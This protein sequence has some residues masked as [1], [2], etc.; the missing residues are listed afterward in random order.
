MQ[1]RTLKLAGF[2]S[3]VEPVE[4]EIAAGLTGIVGPNGC[5]KSNIVEALRWAMGETSA[6][7]MRGGEMD[8]VIFSGSEKRPA[9]NIAEVT[10]VV[11]NDGG[12][13]P[14][15]FEKSPDLEVRRRIERGAGSDY[16]VNGRAVRARDVQL[17]FA[18]A[19]IGASSP[20]MV[21]QG[22]ISAL[23]AAKPSERRFILEDAAG[24]GGLQSR[25]HEAEL[26]L[27]AAE[28]NL[29]QLDT[30]LD[31][32]Q[33]RQSALKRQARQ[34]EKYRQ[35]AERIREI[36][37]LLLH[38]A[39]SEAGARL[40]LAGLAFDE[41]ETSVRAA[42][43]QVASAAALESTMDVRVTLARQEEARAQETLRAARSNQKDVQAQQ[44]Q[45]ETARAEA[46]RDIARSE[47]DLAHEERERD[48][49]ATA[50]ARLASERATLET[51]QPRIAESLHFAQAAEQR[52]LE[53]V[54]EA[55]SAVLS[56]S[57]AIARGETEQ[58][59]LAKQIG[60]AEQ[61]QG[62][63]SRRMEAAQRERDAAVRALSAG[64]DCAGLEAEAEEARLALHAAEGT[65]D[66]V[67]GERTT[68]EA[69]YTDMRDQADAARGAET[70]L[71]AEINGL[72]AGLASSIGRNAG[73]TPV[74]QSIS[75]NPGFEAALAAALGEDSRASLDPAKNHR[76]SELP[77]T[78]LAP[79]SGTNP[80][81]RMVDVPANLKRALA[82]IGV[83][84]AA[85][86]SRLHA[87][88]LPGQA[89]VTLEGGLFRWDGLVR[90]AGLQAGDPVAAILA[91]RNRLAELRSGLA[92]AQQR[93]RRTTEAAEDARAAVDIAAD[94]ER[95]AGQAMAQAI[96]SL[97]RAQAALSEA[98]A[99]AEQETRRIQQA[100]PALRLA[101]QQASE[102]TATVTGLRAEYDALPDLAAGR[103]T[104]RAGQE[105][106]ATA[107]DRLF[108]AAA[109]A[110]ETRQSI[111]AL[112]ARLG[113][114][115]GEALTWET[116]ARTR[117][118][119]LAEISGRIAAAQEVLAGLG[120]RPEQLASELVRLTQGIETAEQ[121]G[122]ASAAT[123][124]RA[125]GELA[126]AR[127]GARLTEQHLGGAREER[128]RAE[129][130]LET[131]REALDEVERA[132]E[133]RLHVSAAELA[134]T[135]VSE[136]EA[137][138]RG[139]L[140]PRL[141]A[142]Q[143]EREALGAVNLRAETELA[144]ATAEVARVEAERADLHEAIMR[145]RQAIGK[146]NRE[147][148]ERLGAA[149]EVVRVHF[150]RLFATLF[151]GGEAELAL[152]DT[153]DP[154]QAGLEVFASPPGKKL[155]ILSLL[156]GGE[157]ALT[158]LALLFAMF[159][160]TPAPVCV[161]DEVDA[162]LD[163]ANVTR[164]C[165]LLDEISAATGT[166]F[167]VITHHRVTMARMNRLYGVTMA[168]RGVSMLVSVDLTAAESFTERESDPPPLRAGRGAG[169]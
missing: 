125:E 90:E 134:E 73:G 95:A 50:L 102:A 127:R 9:R 141:A 165:D 13:V 135:L 70:R 153:G 27:G 82:G 34:A 15:L 40:E 146:L 149:F 161:L 31:T 96:G 74:L 22:R 78:G 89:L 54:R 86:A 92:E 64:R 128:V 51:G 105:R 123:C 55:E 137:T 32:L 159:L 41:A 150:K 77:E 152:T 67:R 131:A 93:T 71:H 6:R 65:L 118:G 14:A 97:Q 83:A 42:M 113:A 104:L 110:R 19:A 126:E 30:V 112:V 60:Q 98:R 39:W 44:R 2:K 168:E 99:R 85:D 52:A 66:P 26:K 122:R 11:T 167:L 69:R 155:Q 169:R 29:T 132:I 47:G 37:A 21:S 76:W 38:C 121:A 166:R 7:R 136:G 3:F 28:A 129:A 148:L 25:R 120:E 35:L 139:E 140:E 20:A 130:G 53:D 72:E 23:I 106:L 114:I 46:R 101:T 18:D 109:R 162:P 81:A 4:L 10:L 24:I 138:G 75:A 124:V 163:D 79:P 43:G 36:E 107:R 103:D 8:D 160:A 151:G 33:S 68:V 12:P 154:L 87:S 17:L 59:V 1:F 157:Q 80:L 147:A 156:S 119:R 145:L 164:F 45:I 94:R 61:R 48:E 58:A 117:A 100:E 5:G 88:L 111:D 57:T 91:R 115:S 84:S 116:R 108:A 56:A 49:A 62:S 158:A 144:E 143:R 63:A 133:E 142:L 16:R